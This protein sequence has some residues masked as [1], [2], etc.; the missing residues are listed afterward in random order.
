VN[1]LVAGALLGLAGSL[2]CA[3]MC[4]PLVLLAAGAGP[5]DSARHRL[6]RTLTHHAGRLAG[7]CLLGVLA[8]TGG[9]LIAEAGL[10]RGIAIAGGAALL[11]MTAARLVHRAP[12]KTSGVTGRLAHAL[13]VLARPLPRHRAW[14]RVALGGLN[15]LLPCGLLY[16]ALVAASGLGSLRDSVVFMAAF[17]AGTV[18]ILALL[19]CSAAPWLRHHARAR[20]VPVGATGIVGVLLIIRGFGGGSLQVMHPDGGRAGTSGTASHASAH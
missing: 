12:R 3:A 19:V 11:L 17:G 20:W 15:A 8:G 5:R 6:G 14:G 9:Q 13:A 2:H 10:R 18:P 7:Y 4:G 1:A 16:A